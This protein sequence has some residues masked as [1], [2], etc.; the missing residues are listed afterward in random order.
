[1][2][3]VLFWTI[4]VVVIVFSQSIDP[5]I[6]EDTQLITALG[7]DYVDEQMVKGTAPLYPPGQDPKPILF[8]LPL[9][10]VHRKLRYRSF[11]ESPSVLFASDAWR[12]IYSARS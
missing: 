1:M 10:P 11:K 9:R 12:C 8:I 3:K 4:F 5:S 7:L 2:K 6:L